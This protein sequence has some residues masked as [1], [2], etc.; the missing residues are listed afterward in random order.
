[1]TTYKS[2]EIPDINKEKESPSNS[3]QKL[4]QSKNSNSNSKKKKKNQS[5]SKKKQTSSKK[6]RKKGNKYK[7]KPINI[8]KLNISTK[9]SF[10]FS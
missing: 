1:M 3:L 7:I 10:F 5:S 9:K 4:D 2:Q 8:E 6:H